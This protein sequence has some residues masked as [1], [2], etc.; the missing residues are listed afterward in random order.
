MNKVINKYLISGFIKTI[1]NVILIFLCIGIILNL[2]EEIEFFKD[3][4][5]GLSLPF[6]LTLTFIPNLL[7]KLLPFFRKNN[8]YKNKKNPR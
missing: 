7:I 3:L 8:I 2:F 5:L 4:D 6:I 1:I